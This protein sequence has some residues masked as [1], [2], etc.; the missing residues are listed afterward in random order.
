MVIYVQRKSFVCSLLTLLG[1]LL[2]SAGCDKA[3][4]LYTD[5][6]F[7]GHKGS[8]SN[9][10]NDAYV[11][12]TLPSVQNVAKKLDGTELDIQMSLDDTPWVWHNTS[13]SGYVCGSNAQDTIPKIRDAEIEKI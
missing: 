10:Y 11:E 2:L 13:L 9:N 6:I 3:P 7:L 4:N 1:I 12:N 5:V 8:G